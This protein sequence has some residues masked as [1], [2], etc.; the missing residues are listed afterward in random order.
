MNTF[1]SLVY[2][3]ARVITSESL[4]HGIRVWEVGLMLAVCS[5]ELGLC[6][7]DRKESGEPTLLLL[8]FW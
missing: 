8:S 3:V 2:L 1:D 4:L 7:M 6:L 5:L